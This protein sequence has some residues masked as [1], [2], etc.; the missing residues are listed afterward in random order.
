MES[1]LLNIEDLDAA[2]KRL[3][4]S[5]EELLPE[6]HSYVD[7]F[8]EYKAPFEVAVKVAKHCCRTFTHRT[9]TQDVLRYVQAEED[10]LKE[11]VIS[12]YYTS[13][14]RRYRSWRDKDGFE[15]LRTRAEEWLAEQEPIFALVREWC[16]KEAVEEFDRVLA[17]REEADRLRALVEDTVRWL[18][19][20]GHP[21]KAALLAKELN[22]SS[23]PEREP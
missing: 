11:A 5:A 18:R 22:K 3:G 16:G 15:I 23:E 4:L 9:F 10:A 7:R 1:E 20:S 8:G 19:F 13:P 6:P 14:D 2:Q 12:G 17:L 21:V